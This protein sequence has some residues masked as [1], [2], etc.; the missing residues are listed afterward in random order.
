MINDLG[1]EQQLPQEG[2]PKERIIEVNEWFTP[3]EGYDDIPYDSLKGKITGPHGIPATPENYRT[4]KLF[5]E[6]ANVGKFSAA[7]W[8]DESLVDPEE[9]RGESYLLALPASEKIIEGVDLKSEQKKMETR[10]MKAEID[11]LEK[12]F[13][14][15][16]FPY[17]LEVEL[18]S[19]A[20]ITSSM[21]KDDDGKPSSFDNWDFNGNK[22]NGL[23]V[24]ETQNLIGKV[25][26]RFV[27]KE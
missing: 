20:I 7:F 3:F 26:F 23:V 14:E 5:F 13:I 6:L 15:R 25:G 16:D 4:K 12:N 21:E 27:P 9:A 17:R 8:W 22:L 18:P 24:P 11:I 10:P 1:R 19:G 2:Q